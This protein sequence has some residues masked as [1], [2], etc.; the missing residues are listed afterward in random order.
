MSPAGSGHIINMA[1]ALSKITFPGAGL[2]V[3]SKRAG[4]GLTHNTA[5]EY[6]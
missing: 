6:D 1:S 3:A 4:G 5:V 2:Y